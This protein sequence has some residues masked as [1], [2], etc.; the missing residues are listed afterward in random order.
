MSLTHNACCNQVHTA[1]NTPYV[2]PDP[3]L[4]RGDPFFRPPSMFNNVVG[5][6][7][8]DWDEQLTDR[9]SWAQ[10]RGS[11]YHISGSSNF[12][13]AKHLTT[14]VRV[15]PRQ[16][17]ARDLQEG[18][19]VERG[20]NVGEDKVEGED[21]EEAREDEGNVDVG[22]K[23]P[24]VDV[25]DVEATANFW[26]EEEMRRNAEE[27][28]MQEEEEWAQRPTCM[29]KPTE[30][31]LDGRT[32]PR[33]R[34]TYKITRVPVSSP[35]DR[36]SSSIPTGMELDTCSQP[37][38]SHAMETLPDDQ[39][40]SAETETMAATTL[41]NLVMLP[42]SASP[43]LPQSETASTSIPAYDEEV[44]R[45]VFEDASQDILAFSPPR[46]STPYVGDI[47]ESSTPPTRPGSF[48]QGQFHVPFAFSFRSFP[49]NI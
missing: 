5:F 43:R 7:N 21:K 15:S 47:G 10:L 13:S 49:K 2:L 23:Q 28:M 11:E 34:I 42:P 17:I 9:D 45:G 14:V 19:G 32:G 29:P 25:G 6:L 22:G 16:V 24:E 30:T 48:E 40:H 20:E 12:P 46:S 36:P 26:K 8:P 18:E 31:N 39:Q 44:L 1:V 33:T 27:E 3:V 38:S 4:F 35:K 41:A 37:S